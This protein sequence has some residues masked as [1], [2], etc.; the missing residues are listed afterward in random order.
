MIIVTV[1]ILFAVCAVLTH[2]SRL[3]LTRRF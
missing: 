3:S 1:A 2:G